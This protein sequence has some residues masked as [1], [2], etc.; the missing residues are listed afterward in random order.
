M[1]EADQPFKR[2]TGCGRVWR[3]RHAMLSD[4]DVALT[5]YQANF[6]DLQEGFFLFT[7][8]DPGCGTTVAM[9]AARFTDLYEGPVF[10]ERLTGTEHCP[11]HCLRRDDLVRC[12]AK[13]ECAFVREVMDM[14]QHW[15]GKKRNAA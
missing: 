5:G 13:C 10:E 1:S 8:R 4:P 12:P 2:C 6:V 11:G 3:T 9:P 14:I 15:P 7:H